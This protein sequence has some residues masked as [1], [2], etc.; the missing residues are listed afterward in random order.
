MSIALMTLAWK[1]EMPCGRK[2]VLVALCDN[3][4]DQGE[5]YPSVSMLAEKC[6]MGERTVQQHIADLEK[7]GIVQRMMRRG[8]STIYYINLCNIRTPA[9]LEPPQN[10][11]TPPVNPAP[12]PPQI[13]HKTSADFAPITVNE[14]SIESSPNRGGRTAQ[15]KTALPVD[16]KLPKKLGEWAL[17]EFP[18]WSA[19]DVRRISDKF[20]DYWLSCGGAKK[21][22]EATWRN[23]CRNE[24]HSWTA[25]A[26]A[27]PTRGYESEKDKARRAVALAISGQGAGTHGRIIDI[28]SGTAVSSNSMG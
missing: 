26:R 7:S 20:H 2:F 1:L 19:E 28:G 11:H 16:W 9:D 5:C 12:P 3:A 25:L 22:W 4:S 14:P 8:R 18:H 17:A 23:W 10:P 13:S 27:A 21:D 6:S 15:R 24:S